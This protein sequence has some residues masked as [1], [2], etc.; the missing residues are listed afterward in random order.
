MHLT[1]LAKFIDAH[2]GTI[3]F[4][5]I[6]VSLIPCLVSFS[7]LYRFKIRELNDWAK[8]FAL[9]FLVLAVLHAIGWATL[10]L[11]T[12]YSPNKLPFSYLLASNAG[13]AI[14]S[15]VSNYYFYRVGAALTRR[16]KAFHTKILDI[17]RIGQFAGRAFIIALFFVV[18]FIST[19]E[20]F[21]LD[22]PLMRIPSDVSLWWIRIPDALLSAFIIGFVGI[23]LSR[24]ISFRR[25]LSMALLATLTTVVYGALLISY[26][27]HPTI[28]QNGWANWIKVT[29]DPGTS[30]PAQTD[31]SEDSLIRRLDLTV[32][33]ASIPL[34]LTL[35]FP[36]YVLML[37]ISSPARIRQLYRKVTDETAEFLDDNGVVYSMKEEIKA[38]KIE[39]YIK[40]PRKKRNKAARYSF[41]PTA[42]MIEKPEVVDFDE[43]TDF[44]SVMSSGKRIL[45]RLVNYSN[46]VPSSLE[47]SAPTHSSVIV[48]PILFHNTVVGCLKAELDY[49]EFTEADMQN[50]R[51]FASLLSP[52][53]QDYREVDGLNEISR[54]LTKLQIEANEYEISHGV[55]EIAKL[56][57]DI[58]SASATYISIEAGFLPQSDIAPEEAKADEKLK[59][60]L[61]HDLL[62]T[63]DSTEEHIYL[64][65]RLKIT[66]RD[67]KNDSNKDGEHFFGRLY[68]KAPIHLN[69][70]ELPTLAVKSVHRH[71]VSNLITEALLNFVRGSLN[72]ASRELAVGLNGLKKANKS[73]G[74]GFRTEDVDTV[75]RW[76]KMIDKIAR[77][78][79][80]GWV[81]ATHPKDKEHDLLGQEQRQLVREL[82]RDELGWVKKKVDTEYA[83]IQAID[84]YTLGDTEVKTVNDTTH[85]IRL[86]FSETKQQMWLGVCN[87]KFKLELDYL[88][89]WSGFIHRF[90]EIADTALQQILNRQEIMMNI[91]KER[92]SIAHRM[93]KV[94]KNVTSPLRRIISVTKTLKGEQY[95]SAKDFAY[96]LSKDV[97]KLEK[98]VEE[99]SDV[100]KQNSRGSCSVQKIVQRA[101]EELKDELAACAVSVDL[102]GLDETKVR[103]PLS[104]AKNA[105][106]VLLENAVEA[107]R[108]EQTK[109]SQISIWVQEERGTLL[110][111]VTD[112][113]VGVSPEIYPHIIDSEVESTKDT[114]S[115]VGLFEFANLLREYGSDI[116]L[117]SCGPNPKTTFTLCFPPQGKIDRTDS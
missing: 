59:E 114:G 36:G 88:S 63:P 57:R 3:S 83:N 38:D 85:V 47:Q 51:R 48:L 112:N 94:M 18:T 37:M 104:I 11:K 56:S 76:F 66:A 99:F 12:Y 68:L 32:Y 29:E 86:S 50:M 74:V 71:A 108:D 78:A 110:C 60:L 28:V 102:K 17:A 46:E 117:T 105:L 49:S 54:G 100:G 92:N 64:P 15:S 40:L 27:V 31:N 6:I 16:S 2:Q 109:E 97:P 14:C 73:G 22:N 84:L 7:L 67:L 25:S 1:D 20:V 4:L 33:S 90:G 115:G 24:N 107:P 19:L 82:E 26:A 87:P 80:L 96:G 81:V 39:L 103:I 45:F 61:K 72:E 101:L 55:K 58:L 13:N 62:N 70:T 44:G 5:S 10:L 34:K 89:P 113:G 116:R 43:T 30:L 106:I 53:V 9:G 77:K 75:Q 42:G 111:H 98:L 93:A 69:K 91:E 23:A 79:Y 52:A 65:E 21:Q 95:K 41:P 35:F 8:P